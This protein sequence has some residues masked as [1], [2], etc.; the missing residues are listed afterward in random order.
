MFLVNFIIIPNLRQEE[1]YFLI[2]PQKA[3]IFSGR[4]IWPRE[5]RRIKKKKNNYNKLA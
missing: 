4:K 2:V 5:R 1:I 3:L